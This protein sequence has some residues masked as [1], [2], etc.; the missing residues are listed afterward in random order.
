MSSE[1]RFGYEWKKYAHVDPLYEGQFQNW[2]APL[3]PDGFRGK[4]VLDAG[5]GMGRNSYW[6]LTYGARI[7]M[8]FDNDDRSVDAA[9]N[10]LAVFPNAK[11]LK[12]SIY[13]INWNRE[14]DIVFS[15]GVIHHLKDPKSALARL[16]ESLRPGGILA[17]W[18]YSYEG[19]KWIV[20]YV[21]PIRIHVTSKL[22]V[23]M[24]HILAYICSV[25]LWFFLKITGGTTPY[26]KQI[27]GFK[28]W[29]VHSIVFDQLIPDVAHYWREEEILALVKGLPLRDVRVIPP[30]NKSGW[31]LIGTKI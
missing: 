14:F 26:L 27:A 11:V 12:K 2:M 29:H 21:N 17:I 20:K 9:R 18:V 22:P 3:M 8:A 24:T 4:D 31:I 23:S 19:N 7:V 16:I 5:C 10:N 6:A 13:D 1:Q 25:P 28:F 30:P 15:I